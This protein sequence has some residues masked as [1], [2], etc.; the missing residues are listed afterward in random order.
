MDIETFKKSK[1]ISELV[2]HERLKVEIWTDVLGGVL[3]YAFLNHEEL[4]EIQ[5]AQVEYLLQ[6]PGYQLLVKLMFHEGD[7]Q[8]GIAYVGRLQA[9]SKHFQ[10]MQV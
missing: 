8:D 4:S 9:M 3:F 2:P 5:L 6:E 1:P 7:E 10:A